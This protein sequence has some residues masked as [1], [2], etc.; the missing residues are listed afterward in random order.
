[1]EMKIFESTLPTYEDLQIL[2]MLFTSYIPPPHTTLGNEQRLKLFFGVCNTEGR[3][4]RSLYIS[5]YILLSPLVFRVKGSGWPVLADGCV[6]MEQS[7]TQGSMCVGFCSYTFH[8][9]EY[10]YW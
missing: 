8:S 2:R 1:M 3:E 7:T 6:G 10:I 4:V 5:Y 9:T